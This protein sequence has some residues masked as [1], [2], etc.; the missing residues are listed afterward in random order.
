MATDNDMDTRFA[1]QRPHPLSSESTA[2]V[3][4]RVPAEAQ[5]GTYRLRHFGD[6]K[7]ILG[8]TSPFSGVSGGRDFHAKS[9]ARQ[10]LS[11]ASLDGLPWR[12]PPR[13]RMPAP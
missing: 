9:S 6:A 4:W 10:P 13:Q 8:G 5:P 2:K 12:G 1:W 7:G 3:S 11:L